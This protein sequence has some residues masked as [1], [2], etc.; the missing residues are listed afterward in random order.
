MHEHP[1][2]TYS[3]R[4]TRSLPF[5]KE[6]EREI[7]CVNGFR[8]VLINN[9]KL[10]VLSFVKFL[11]SFVVNSIFFPNLIRLS[12]VIYGK[13]NKIAWFEPQFVN[14]HDKFLE[15]LVMVARAT[16]VWYAEE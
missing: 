9:E 16:G 5:C 11:K 6:F 12:I 1:R 13:A 8:T 2:I 15:I 4:T 14:K 3:F 10:F 7:S